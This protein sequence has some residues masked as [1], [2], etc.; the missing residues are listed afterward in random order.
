VWKLWQKNRQIYATSTSLGGTIKLSLHDPDFCQFGFTSEFRK[1]RNYGSELAGFPTFIRWRRNRASAKAVTLA[2]LYFPT[3]Q[4]AARNDVSLKKVKNP[5]VFPPAK[6]GGCVE[7]TLAVIPR[8]PEDTIKAR[9]NATLIGWAPL[10]HHESCILV[11]RHVVSSFS[12]EDFPRQIRIPD[13]WVDSQTR[14][15]RNGE[16]IHDKN[17]ITWTHPRDY[18]FIEIAELTGISLTKTNSI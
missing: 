10:G 9:G 12:K 7:L 2:K 14:E 6:E 11:G 3:D 18:E 5:I 15:L 1:Q 4:L 16:I 13:E 8:T 17:V